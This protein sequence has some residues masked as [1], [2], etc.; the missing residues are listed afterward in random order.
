MDRLNVGRGLKFYGRVIGIALLALPGIALQRLFVLLDVP[1]QAS[2]PVFF[3]RYVS[4]ILGIRRIV[5]GAPATERPLML[6]ANHVS[7]L[8]IIVLSAV[9]PVSF[10]AK[11]EVA[12]WGVFGL[13]AKLQRSI[14]V[15]RERRTETQAVNG[16]IAERLAKG[17][18]MVL[19]AEGTTG[20]GVR[21]LPFRSA[22]IGAARDV[23]SAGSDASLKVWLQPVSIAYTGLAGLPAGRFDR[24][25]TAWYGD[26]TLPPHL[27]AILTGGAL[28]ATIS[29]GTPQPYGIGSDRKRLTRLLEEEVRDLTML[30]HNGRSPERAA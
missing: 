3:H 23:L 12:S 21:L 27:R 16:S 10:I 8:D 25:H 20:D 24:P 15:D 7:W 9:M 26:M 11:S 1:L 4:R 17:D 14:F 28:D 13:F 19:F 2:F 5:R 18:V 6:V 30:A 29:F 22:L